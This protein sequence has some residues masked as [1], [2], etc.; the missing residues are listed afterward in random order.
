MVMVT[1]RSA[2]SAKPSGY[3][4]S[5]SPNM[6]SGNNKAPSGKTSSAKPNAYANRVYAAST[7]IAVTYNESGMTFNQALMTYNDSNFVVLGS[8]G[9]RGPHITFINSKL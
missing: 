3:V 8:G 6:V 2:T 4:D 5:T 1:Y 7:T 9:D